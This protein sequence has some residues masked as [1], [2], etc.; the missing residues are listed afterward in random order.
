MQYKFNITDSIDE[1]IRKALIVYLATYNKGHTG[2]SEYR[3]LAVILRDETN[4]V[5]G[6]LWG[7]TCYGWLSIQLLVVPEILRGR[8]IGKKIML[9]AEREAISRGCHSAWLDTY[10]F[11][12]RGFYE[13]LGYVS[14]GELKN[15]P[16]GFS[17]FFLQKTL[18]PI[19]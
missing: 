8:G 4:A 5:I 6:G 13:K 9:H 10:E 12:A 11:Q 16:T 3:E 19:G 7:A 2:P 18:L 17:R 15:Y 1:D 14:F